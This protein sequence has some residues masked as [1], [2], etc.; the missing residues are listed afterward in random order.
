MLI[1]IEQRF[2]SLADERKTLEEGST[3]IGGQRLEGGRALLSEIVREVR[4]VR[5]ARGGKCGS[6]GVRGTGFSA[7]L[8]PKRRSGQKREEEHDSS[9]ESREGSANPHAD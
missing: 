7:V 4:F 3:L 8:R 9:G 5:A 6:E 1:R 2:S